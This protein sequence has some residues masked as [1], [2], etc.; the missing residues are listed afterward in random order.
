MPMSFD[1][2]VEKVWIAVDS[3]GSLREPNREHS[4]RGAISDFPQYD[5]F[6]R[7]PRGGRDAGPAAEGAGEV[8][9]VG[10]SEFL[11]DLV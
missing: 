7:M 3:R 8:G 4:D 9:L 6:V 10:V 5:P 1:E 2:R 11:R